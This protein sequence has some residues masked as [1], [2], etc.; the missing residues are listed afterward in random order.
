VKAFAPL[1][2]VFVFGCGDSVEEYMPLGEGNRW[3]YEVRLDADYF[4]A[5]M[6]VERAASVGSAR[7]WLLASDLG[8]CRMAWSDGELIAAELAGTTYAPPVPLFAE[9]GREWSGVV[10]TPTTKSAATARLQRS[11][12]DLKIAGRTYG[13]VKCV[14]TLEG[15]GEKTQL[16][17]WFFPGLGI[18]RQEQRS[19]PALTRDRRIDFVSGP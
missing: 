11:K 17:T 15:S 7:G 13:T 14:L 2:L 3:T 19:G 1:L 10:T 9:S 8:Q 4:D 18:L 12:E 5:D 16:T 6:T